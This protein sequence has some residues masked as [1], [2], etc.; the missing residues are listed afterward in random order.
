MAEVIYFDRRIIALQQ[1]LCH[2]AHAELTRKYSGNRNF[3]ET[4][5]D[6]AT[7]T[8]IIMDGMY[9]YEDLINLCPIIT[10]RLQQKRSSIIVIG[11]TNV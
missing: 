7:E 4:I 8:N 10:E 2:P 11:A 3:D 1:E 5:R 9:S 6:L